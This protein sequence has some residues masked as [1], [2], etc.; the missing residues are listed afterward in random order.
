MFSDTASPIVTIKTGKLKGRTAVDE[1]GSTYLS[2]QGIPYAKPPLGSL[3]FK[4][5][6]PAEQWDGIKDATKQGKGCYA[7]NFLGNGFVGAEDCL[8]LNV[9]SPGIHDTQS[10][11]PVMFWIHGGGF[12]SGSSK[13]DLYGP[14]YLMREN[15]VLVTINYRLGVLGFLR[16]Q[17]SSLDVPGNAGLKDIVLALKWVQENIEHFGG[18]PN[19]V[20][21]FGESAGGAAV[22]YLMLSPITKGLFHK[23]IAQSG[24]ALNSWARGD[25]NS[26][27]K[28]ANALEIATHDE[29]TILKILQNMP[30]KD[31]FNNGVAK[32]RDNFSPGLLRPFCPVIEDYK[33]ESTFLY[34]DPLEII[35]NGNYQRV[36][37]IMGCTS[38]E[39]MILHSLI[40]KKYLLTDNN[41]VPQNIGLE[42]GSS[43]YKEA[44]EKIKKF[45]MK[46][47]SDEDN[48][49][50]FF[51][52]FT[53]NYF[54]L[55]VY[56]SIKKHLE[57]TNQ[58]IY[59]YRFSLD[60]NMNFLKRVFGI[61]SPGACH[62]DD[63]PY[64][65]KGVAS[66]QLETNSPEY[67]G[68]CRMTKMWADFARYGNPTPNPSKLIPISW[69]PT[70]KNQF[71]YLDIGNE[72]KMEVDLEKEAMEFWDTIKTT[73]NQK[74][75][76]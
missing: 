58:P 41:L 35:S 63:I 76:L 50:N 39:G 27:N 69:Q 13:T 9:Y 8:F 12:T 18:N 53:D 68:M 6:Q 46:G 65:F 75:K 19:N 42:P 5:P 70:S 34:E 4:A 22:H 3:R 32:I 16:L 56:E 20:T 1:N 23:A 10:L 48:I 60:T 44:A 47:K 52:L 11:K 54:L 31:L 51:K 73:L 25:P 17:D 15:V 72:L 36:P 24:C 21:I 71:N 49:D 30:L 74:S 66:P 43:L 14:E 26:T 37:M 29:K 64:L 55:G 38:R 7:R 2:F 40:P 33:D 28:L 67:I 45:Y 62:V 59:F 57:T 61:T